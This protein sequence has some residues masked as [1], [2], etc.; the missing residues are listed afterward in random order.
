MA[1]RFTYLEK[2]KSLGNSGEHTVD[3]TIQDPITQIWVE[4]RCNNGAS[5]N[6][7][8]P[9][10]L[11]IDALEIIDGSTVLWSLDGA[12][13]LGM[14]SQILGYM[15]YQRVCE[16]PNDPQSLA[17]P[18]LFGNFLGDVERSFDPRRFVNPQLR[19]KWNLA[20]VNAVGATGFADSGLTMTAIAEV[21][22]GAPAPTRMLSA[23]E[24]YTYT[25]AAGTEYIELPRDYPYKGLMIRPVAT[26][27]HWYEVISNLKLNV[28]GSKWV[29]FDI[30]GEDLQYLLFQRTPMLHYRHLFHCKS[31]DT[32]YPILKEVENLMAINEESYDMTHSYINYEYGQQSIYMYNAG[33]A[34]TSYFNMGAMVTG[35]FPFHC[36]YIPF[37]DPN[38]PEEW[39]QAQQ[40]GSV[41]L[42]LTGLLARSVYVCLLQDRIM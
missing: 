8:N 11:N 40:F 1:R 17:L 20:N 10:H 42:E 5:W 7:A 3:I 4:M 38:K 30:G 29:P 6:H 2:D 31:G 16:I 18:I 12:E 21:M 28:D 26:T 33:T 24:V 32:I 27:S 41:R 22:E 36:V 14:V 37:G 19:V 9:M 35:Y 25:A 23:K 13:M 39:F 34:T 15:P